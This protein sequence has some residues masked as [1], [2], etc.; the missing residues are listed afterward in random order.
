MNCMKLAGVPFFKRLFHEYYVYIDSDDYKADYIMVNNKVKGNII[1]EWIHPGEKYRLIQIR[2]KKKSIQA[3]E[4]SMK[5]LERK[6][7]IAGNN[8]YP[9]AA[10]RLCNMLTKMAEEVGL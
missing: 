5:E 6:Q 9:E 3:F 8:D 7:L 4:D 2:V 1:N 10:D